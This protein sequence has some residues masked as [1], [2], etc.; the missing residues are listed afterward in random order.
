VTTVLFRL[1]AE[2]RARWRAWLALAVLAGLGAAVILTLL[3]GARRTDAAYPAFA[4]A[5]HAS[6]VLLGGRSDFGLVGSVDL[7]DVQRLPEVADSARASVP[8]L[9]TG[10]INDDRR[11]GPSDL[12][13]VAAHDARLGTDIERWKMLEGRRADPTRIGEATASFELADRL[14]LRVGVRVRLHFVKAESFIPVA[15]KLLSEF[16]PRLEGGRGAQASTLEQLADGPE[17]TFH[18]VGIEASPAEFPP[19]SPD[20][21]PVLHLTPAFEHEYAAGVVGSPVMYTVFHRRDQLDTFASGVERLAPGKPVGFVASR[22]GQT[23][24]VQR[25][26]EVQADALRILAAL[27]L[28]ALLVIVGQALVRQA[29]L[30]SAQDDVYRALGMSRGQVLAVAAGAGSAIGIAA[31]LAAVAGAYLASPLMPIGLARTA[32]IGPGLSFDPL[33]LGVGAVVVA[34]V[35]PALALFAEW[36]V[37]RVRRRDAV[38]TERPVVDRVLGDAAI[39]PVPSRASG[40]PRELTDLARV[41]SLPLVLAAI[42]GVLAAA[43]LAHALLTSVRRRRRELAILK[44]LGLRRGQIA[45]VVAWQTSTLVALALLLGIPLGMIAGRFAWNTFADGLGVPRSLAYPWA[46]IIAAVPIALLLG[47]AIAAVPAWI[48]GRT[49]PAVVFR[50]G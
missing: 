14:H 48:A 28:V 7:D 42:L 39:P 8:L 6:D 15:A 17:I 43:T 18:V 22:Q 4:R 40:R 25:S 32:D 38:A 50:G 27:T 10:R 16:G 31:A 13:P 46:L 23:V 33:V 12:F 1:R 5:Q 2:A 37:A 9:F 20:L 21:S 34:L 29:F 26:I 19:L 47:N 49:R 41:R 24:K 3:A 11:V 45:R 44:T 35:V 30:E 36:R